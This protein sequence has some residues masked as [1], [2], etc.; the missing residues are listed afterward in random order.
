MDL[1]GPQFLADDPVAGGVT[2]ERATVRLSRS[3]GI[4]AEIDEKKIEHYAVEV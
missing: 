4:G 3:S 2:V 1:N